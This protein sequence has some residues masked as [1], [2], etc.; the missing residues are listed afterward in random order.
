MQMLDYTSSSA[1]STAELTLISRRPYSL[2]GVGHSFM[3]RQIDNQEE[4]ISSISKA[5]GDHVNVNVTDFARLHVRAQLAKIASTDILVGMHGAALSYVVFLPPW[6][7]M[8]EM[9]PRISWKCFQHMSVLSGI[10][11][12]RWENRGPVRRDKSG[13]YTT[14][15]VDEFIPIVLRAVDCAWLRSN[16]SSNGNIL[17]PKNVKKCQQ[18]WS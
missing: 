11:Y 16:L 14:V 6:A 2:A 9:W 10:F 4:V 12:Q 8:V 3:A 17:Q 18:H 1:R 7:S 5:V 15:N 13:D